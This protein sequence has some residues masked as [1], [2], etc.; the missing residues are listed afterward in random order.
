MLLNDKSLYDISIQERAQIRNTQIGFLFQAFNL[1]PWLTALENVQLPHCLSTSECR[2]QQDH[3]LELLKRFG[4]ADRVN[5]KPLELSAGQQ[6]RVAMARTLSM[7]PQLI[8]A[9]EPT[10]N[11][12][13]ESRDLVLNTMQ[14]LCESGCAIVLVTHDATVSDAAQRVLN[15]SDGNVQESPAMR[16]TSAA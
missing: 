15:I 9:D 11:L 14:E 6:Q 16:T 5:H 4:L 12:D 1:I 2:T 8:L 7:S 10:G 13:P 3:A